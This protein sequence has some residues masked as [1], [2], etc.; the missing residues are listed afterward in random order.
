MCHQKR[1]N[2]FPTP[3]PNP[4]KQ[5]RTQFCIKFACANR[6]VDLEIVEITPI[7]EIEIC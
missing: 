4:K 5:S 1:R 6:H 3:H 7:S 2:V